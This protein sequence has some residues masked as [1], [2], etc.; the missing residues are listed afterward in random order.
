MDLGLVHN[1]S[2]HALPGYFS[3]YTGLSQNIGSESYPYDEG[4]SHYIIDPHVPGSGFVGEA[5]ASDSP[6]PTSSPNEH[7]L[8]SYSPDGQFRDV[9]FP[10]FSPGSRNNGH[11]H[12]I[13]PPLI[14]SN[15]HNPS[16]Q[17]NS[18]VCMVPSTRA[19]C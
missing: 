9:P 10:V 18:E 5:G 14:Q 12:T 4:F 7:E 1:Q 8:Q 2:L 11:T 19:S 13:L 16:I 17:F 3:A 15:P 6:E